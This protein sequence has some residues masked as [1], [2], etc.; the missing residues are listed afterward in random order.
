MIPIHETLPDDHQFKVFGYKTYRNDLDLFLK[1]KSSFSN[2]IKKELDN[3]AGINA[4]GFTLENYHKYLE[5]NNI[6]HHKFISKI[7]R[8][9]NFDDIDMGYIENIIKIANY[10]FNKH[11]SIYNSKIEFRVVR[12]NIEDNNDLHRDH[13]FP[14]FTPL[15]NIYLPL[16]GSYV[17]SALGIV[18]FSHDWT[19]EDV[20]PTFTFEESQA[21]KKYIKNG[22]A[23]SVPG[24]KSCKKETNIHRADLTQGD[25]MLFSPKM[26]HGGGTNGSHETRF[27][28]EIRL[29]P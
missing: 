27:S 4:K 9:V 11:F 3:F 28:F 18:P 22:I 20:I 25:F 23:Y 24:I 15:V 19:D 1:L 14:Y 21:G 16:A 13:W 2:Y 17:N 8:V 10:D 7:S 29:E 6:D 26:V 12:P 5:K